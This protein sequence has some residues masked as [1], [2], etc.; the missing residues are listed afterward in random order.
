MAKKSEK[1]PFRDRMARRR[2]SRLGPVPVRIPTAEERAQ[3]EA[4]SALRLRLGRAPRREELPPWLRE[5]LT[6]S[7]GSLSSALRQLGRGPLPAWEPRA[8][9]TAA[10]PVGPPGEKISAAPLFFVGEGV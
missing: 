2:Q 5:E 6:A 8:E 4:L 1:H 7:F 9:G 10:D 3:L